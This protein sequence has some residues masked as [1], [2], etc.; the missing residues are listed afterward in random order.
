MPYLIEAI[1]SYAKLGEII[2]LMKEVFRVYE[3][4]TMI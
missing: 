1:R 2:Q 3:E 4:P